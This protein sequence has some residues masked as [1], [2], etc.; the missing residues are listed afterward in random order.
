MRLPPFPIRLTSPAHTPIPLLS[1]SSRVHT[2]Q[3]LG[4]YDPMAKQSNLNAPA[5]KAWLAKGAQPSETV[6]ALLKRSLI[7]E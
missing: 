5:I 2:P 7:I 1:L 6:G 3:E 4:W